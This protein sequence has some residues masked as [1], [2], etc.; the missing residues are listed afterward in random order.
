[1]LPS[2]T[3]ALIGGFSDSYVSIGTDLLNASSLLGCFPLPPP[4]IPKT[5]VMISTTFDGSIDPWIIPA[6][7]DI[8]S[9]GDQMPLSPAELAYQ[10]IQITSE[11][12]TAMV[13]TNGT[14]LPPITVLS[15][16]LLNEVLPT[17]EA[18]RE[19]MSLEERP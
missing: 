10:A 6:P 1:M 7:S 12:S 14:N 9:Y 2:S 8:D 17:H 13:S 11:P 16:Y 4:E 3:I 18:I 19:I 5:I 15:K